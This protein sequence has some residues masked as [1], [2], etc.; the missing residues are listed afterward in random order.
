MQKQ[1]ALLRIIVGCGDK[2]LEAFQ[3]ADNPLDIEFVKD[4]ERITERSRHELAALVE[5]QRAAA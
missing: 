3:A 4:F 2:A 5:R 1:I